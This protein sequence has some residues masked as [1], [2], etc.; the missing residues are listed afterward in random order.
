MCADD[1][2][3]AVG[4]AVYG[5]YDLCGVSLA[6]RCCLMRSGDGRLRIQSFSRLRTH[7]S[8]SAFTTHALTTTSAASSAAST[9]ALPSPFLTR[10]H[11]SRHCLPAQPPPRRG[12]L[13][14]E[15]PV[16]APRRCRCRLLP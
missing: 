1:S 9:Y 11:S 14:R 4:I 16:T 7:G 3:T 10:F 5:G 13:P 2:K 15:A 8:A 12:V 6:R